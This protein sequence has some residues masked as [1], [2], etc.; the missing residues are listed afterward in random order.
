MLTLWNNIFITAKQWKPIFKAL[1]PISEPFC[2]VVISLSR[3][4]VRQK[5]FLAYY[6][7]VYLQYQAYALM[8]FVIDSEEILQSQQKYFRCYEIQFLKK[9]SVQ[10]LVELGAFNFCIKHEGFISWKR[11][12]FTYYRKYFISRVLQNMTDKRLK[13]TEKVS[14]CIVWW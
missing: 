7:W 14:N 4:H 5:R 13:S 11:N 10:F 1:S 6:F 12:S 8:K 3:N 9:W 2:A